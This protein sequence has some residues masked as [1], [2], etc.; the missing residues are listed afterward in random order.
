VRRIAAVPGNR[1]VQMMCS[2]SGDAA[3]F[4]V[5]SYW[6]SIE[7][8]KGYAGATYEQVRDLPRDDEFLIGKETLVR[9][10]EL[11]VDFRPA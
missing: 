5:V 11:D 1:G 6:D 3:E 2:R 7:A 8:I 4:V 10:F 9:H